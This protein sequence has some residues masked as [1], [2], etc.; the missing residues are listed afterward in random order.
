[1]VSHYCKLC[2]IW[3]RLEHCEYLKSIYDCEE[4]CYS[5]TKH[6]KSKDVLS[7]TK[8][9]DTKTIEF[10]PESHLFYFEFYLQK[11][12]KIYIIVMHTRCCRGK[13]GKKFNNKPN[14]G[15]S[16]SKNQNISRIYLRKCVLFCKLLYFYLHK[17]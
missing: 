13:V 16:V 3:R 17:P 15:K 5:I 11:L 7:N 10:S 14:R 8:L 1:M 4:T 12:Q 9:N 2:E 6:I